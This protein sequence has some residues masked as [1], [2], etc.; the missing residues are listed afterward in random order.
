MIR[1]WSSPTLSLT[2]SCA[3][4]ESPDIENYLRKVNDVPPS[5]SMGKLCKEDPVSV[6][7]QFSHKFHSFFRRVLMKGGRGGGGLVR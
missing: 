3:K 6:Y 4:Y 5:Y 2:F 7:R 1:K